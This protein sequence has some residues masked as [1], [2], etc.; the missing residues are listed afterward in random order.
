MIAVSGPA[1]PRRTA[2]GQATRARI[3]AVAAELADH[4]GV[5]NTGIDDVR[6]VAGVSGSQMSHYFGDKRSLVR[7]VIRHQADAVIAMQEPVLS[8]LDSWESLQAWTDG[9]VAKLERQHCARGCEYGSLASELAETDD[10]TRQDL[11]NGFRRWAGLIQTGLATMRERGELRPDADPE[12]L[13]YSLLAA[14]QGG[15]L[16]AQTLRDTTVLRSALNAALAYIGSFA[17]GPTSSRTTPPRHDV[18]P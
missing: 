2:K 17:T 6:R 3:V 11:A 7:A 9:V 1:E 18:A 4:R 14:Q 13:A 8:N 12:A 10:E 16:L 5:A 15:V